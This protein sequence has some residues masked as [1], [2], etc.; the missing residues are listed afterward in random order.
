GVPGAVRRRDRS[1]PRGRR[2]ILIEAGERTDRHFDAKLLLATQ[3]AA[4]GHPVILDDRTLPDRLERYQKYE[5]ARFLADVDRVE[6]TRV[7]IIG[8]EAIG[9]DTLTALRCRNGAAARR[10][11]GS[12]TFPAG[13]FGRFVA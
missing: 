7:I 9:Q 8:A 12:R 6:V 4:R 2:M 1:V 11:S 13:K 3:L 5:A 10:R